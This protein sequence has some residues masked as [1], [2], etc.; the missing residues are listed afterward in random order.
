MVLV[1]GTSCG[2]LRRDEGRGD[3]WTFRRLAEGHPICRPTPGFPRAGPVA[4]G[5]RS[6]ELCRPGEDGGADCALGNS[7]GQVA[8]PTATP[9]PGA[10]EEL[11]GARAERRCGAAERAEQREPLAGRM[12]RSLPCAPPGPLRGAASRAGDPAFGAAGVCVGAGLTKTHFG[13]ARLP[14]PGPAAHSRS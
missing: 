8:T 1:P 3:K 9:T 2:P 10:S 5:P 14:D 4:W 7:Q 12:L 6:G 13:G 11:P